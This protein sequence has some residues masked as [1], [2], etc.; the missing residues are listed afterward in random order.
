M[1]LKHLK[2]GDKFIPAA[3]VG[4]GKEVRYI[5]QDILHD[6]IVCLNTSTC[7][8]EKRNGEMVVV[9]VDINNKPIFP[10]RDASGKRIPEYHVWRSILTRCTNDP[11][12]AG[13]G[14][15][16][17]ERWKDSFE[18]FLQDMGYR[19]S[20]E[21]SIDRIDNNGNYAPENCRWATIDVQGNNRRINVFVEYNG[22]KL[23]VKQ[24]AARL[25]IKNDTLW[26]RLFVHK[27][28]T[29]KAFTNPAR[30]W[31]KQLFE[32]YQKQNT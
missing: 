15:K 28:A 1:R 2:E 29:E 21:H 5:V 20:P 8:I 31:T 22:E 26:R 4:R 11:L 9:L 18:F 14:I 19:P 12:Y 24:W 32:L 30:K 6:S 17:C 7:E 27:W 13:R 25:G 10:N 16:V 23:T 3:A